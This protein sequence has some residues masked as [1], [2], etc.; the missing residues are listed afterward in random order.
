MKKIYIIIALMFAVVISNAQT[1]TETL[2]NE[3]VITLTKIGLQ[4]SVIITKIKSSNTNFDVSTDA[5]INLNKE[6][7]ASEVINEMM[8][9]DMQTKTDLANQTDSKDPNSMH[10]S[11]IYYYNTNDANNPVRK[12]DAIRVTSFSSSG[13]GYGGFGGTTQLAHVSGIQSKQ[14]FTET[15]PVFYFYFESNNS[16]ADWYDDASSPNEFVLVKFIEKK[17]E[18]LFKTGSSSSAGYG[19]SA[20][21]GVPEKDKIPFDYTE[22]SEG[23]YKVTFKNPLPIGEYCFVFATATNKVFDFGI[24]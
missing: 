4:P 21:V 7:V 8:K 2:T 22:V 15:S 10:K 3:N 6:G 19:S 5:L 13:G 20:R 9:T 1:T 24:H 12:I 16:R 18:R 11:G 23:I 14:Q 17:N